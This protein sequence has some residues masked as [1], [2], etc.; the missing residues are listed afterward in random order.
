MSV[1]S[2]GVLLVASFAIVAAAACAAQEAG[3][4]N[5]SVAAFRK[6]ERDAIAACNALLARP[7]LALDV[8][9]A[10]F[11]VRGRAHY[12]ILELDRADAD[13]ESATALSPQDA[14]LPVRR[15]WIA[16]DRGNPGLV[17]EFANKA[18]EIDPNFGHVFDLVGATLARMGRWDAALSAYEEGIAAS[19]DDPQ[20]HFSRFKALIALD[21]QRDALVEAD[22]MSRLP[23]GPMSEPRVIP[24]RG[25]VF[26]SFRTA[27]SLEQ[28]SLLGQMGRYPEATAIYNKVVTDDPSALT[29]AWRAYDRL[30][31]DLTPSL[32]REDV[33]KAV[34]L[35]PSYW[36]PHLILG[37]VEFNAKRYE[38]AAAEF[39]RATALDPDRGYVHWWKARSLRLLGRI[40]D[41]TDAA[42]AAVQRDPGFISTEFK[43]LRERGYLQ[44]LPPNPSQSPVVHDAVR[45]CMLDERC[46]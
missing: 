43:S 39:A 30:F 38:E 33:E 15:G 13:F 1:R 11:K 42:L 16:L 32:I 7:D 12:M 45:A 19:P 36:Y 28:A 2:I 31:H 44:T 46:W 35:D 27:I 14:E 22:N 29:Y 17:A 21:R 3:D 26:T 6:S 41:A 37:R 20:V 18:L 9:A 40:D 5:C 10:A 24:M 4:P 34:S 8:R 25:E 23:D